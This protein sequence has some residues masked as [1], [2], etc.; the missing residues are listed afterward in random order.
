MVLTLA[1]EE[2]VHS[3]MLEELSIFVESAAND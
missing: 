3:T 2:V 1:P